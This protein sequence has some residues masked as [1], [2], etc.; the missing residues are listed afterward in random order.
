VTIPANV[1]L[2]ERRQFT[3]ERSEYSGVPSFDAGLDAYYNST[4][5]QA[6]TYVL[7]NG[8]WNKQ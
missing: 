4:K 8:K 1:E 3:N 2:T 6:G 7:Q 5:K